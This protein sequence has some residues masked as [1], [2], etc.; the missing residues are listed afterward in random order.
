VY[1]AGFEAK[2]FEEDLSLRSLDKYSYPQARSHIIYMK[3]LFFETL[4]AQNKG[5]FALVHIFPGLV[6]GPGF[7]DPG[8][9]A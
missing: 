7:N 5:K 1:A 2:L 6:L 8:Y 4:A 9:P 3:T